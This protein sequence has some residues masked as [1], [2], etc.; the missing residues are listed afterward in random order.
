VRNAIRGVCFAWFCFFW[1]A[2]CFCCGVLALIP[3]PRSGRL[4]YHVFRF[5]GWGFL[6]GFGAGVRVEN[7]ERLA[8]D[9][10]RLVVANHASW[11]DPPA[12]LAAR[13][14][15]LRFI[16][17]KELMKVPFV[18]WYSRLAGHYLLDREDP[19]AAKALMARAVA[20]SRKYGFHPL[21]F[22]EGT[23]SKDGRLGELKPGSFQLAIDGDM[24]IQPIAILGSYAM[25]PSGTSSPRHAGEIVLRI[26][27]PIP[28]EGLKGSRGRRELA[29]RVAE[30]LHALGVG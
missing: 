17:K 14:L 11:V 26:G 28:V 20:N 24:E 27:E 23:R 18:G 30:A 6:F 21:V 12:L 7:G 3:A 5:W 22:P 9:K 29:A 13:G 1:T 25:M 15:R 8:T 4:S 2:F 10:P 16:L 19:R